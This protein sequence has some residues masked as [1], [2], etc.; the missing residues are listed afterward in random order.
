MD[1]RTEHLCK[2][3]GPQVA[4][5]D[6]SFSVRTGEVVGFLGPNG[7]GKTTTMRMICGLT[8]PD[9]GRVLLGGLT[10]GP[11]VVELRRHVGYLPESNPL[12]EDMPVLDLLRFGARLQGLASGKAEK[13]IAWLVEACGLGDEKHKRTG[14]L[15]R[16]Y[17]QRTGLALALVHDPAVLVLDE[18]TTGL[19]PNQIM[20]IRALIK[21]LGREK[22]VVFSTHILS[23]AEAVC[24]RMLIINKGR[25]VA[26]GTPRE[27]RA[28]GLGGAVYMVRLAGA[29]IR[30]VLPVLRNL[31]QV[32]SAQPGVDGSYEVRMTGPGAEVISAACTAQGWAITE[33]RPV[34]NRLEDVFRDATLN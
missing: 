18:P 9:R 20:E 1:L 14:E 16:G 19:D 22:T 28:K 31:P 21:D 32:T 3:Y 10:M 27:M 30:E 2:Q 5:D 29:D 4:V 12:Y 23:E 13:R 6:L 15:S 33:L 26:E 7:A 24:D 8:P 25:L 11:R 34:E 17:R